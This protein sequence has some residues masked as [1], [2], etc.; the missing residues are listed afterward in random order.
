MHTNFINFPGRHLFFEPIDSVFQI[1]YS[2]PKH[3]ELPGIKGSLAGSSNCQLFNL[4]IISAL[5]I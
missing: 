4:L 3:D 2:S 1:T 5:I